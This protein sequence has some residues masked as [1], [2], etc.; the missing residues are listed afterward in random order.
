MSSLGKAASPAPARVHAQP[1]AAPVREVTQSE[2]A[3]KL[4]PAVQ[5]AP[6]PAAMEAPLRGTSAP[7]RAP[8]EQ[9][10]Q[11]APLRQSR[12]EMVARLEPLIAAQVQEVAAVMEAESL[13]PSDVQVMFS[14]DVTGDEKRVCSFCGRPCCG[15][16]PVMYQTKNIEIDLLEDSFV[17]ATE[18]ASRLGITWGALVYDEQ[19]LV[20][21]ELA[22]P[23]EQ[24]KQENE[25]LLSRFRAFVNR[26]QYPDP[27]NRAWLD[28]MLAKWQPGH[29][30]TSVKGQADD[31]SMFTIAQKLF[32][33][34]KTDGARGLTVSK[35]QPPASSLKAQE[36]L[37]KAKKI[38]VHG[39]AVGSKAD[40]VKAGMFSHTDVVHDQHQAREMVGARIKKLIDKTT[41]K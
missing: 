37:F 1:A 38:R 39:L 16:R 31:R 9:V 20:M 10:S 17:V 11:I 40:Q 41:A 28:Q 3:A 35:S 36:A 14:F 2:L 19:V 4:R 23:E 12:V 21:R 30:N 15:Y 7:L 27:T 5:P 26:K 32:S 29:A 33:G 22:A 13:G 18:V 24:A 8:R 25:L 6:A 34:T